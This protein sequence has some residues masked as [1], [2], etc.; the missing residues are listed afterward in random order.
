MATLNSGVTFTA[1]V[2]G[3]HF[4]SVAPRLFTGTAGDFTLSVSGVT[5]PWTIGAEVV[6]G[7][8]FNDVLE[9][10]AGADIVSGGAG[11]DI[12][13]GQSGADIIYGN[14]EIDTL[15]GGDGNDI[16]YGGQNNALNADG[17]RAIEDVLNT[18]GFTFRQVQTGG[19]EFLFGGSGDDILYGNFG[20]DVFSGDTGADTI[21]GGQGDDEANGGSENDSLF[22]NRG[23]DILSGDTG[24]DTLNGGT[25]NDTLAGGTG[26]DVFVFN[27]G[28]GTDVIGDFVAGTDAIQVSANLNGNSTFAT[29]D[30]VSLVTG[31]GTTGE[32]IINLG[33]NADG[34]ANSIKLTGVQANAVTSDFF[35]FG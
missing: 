16:I 18:D 15:S 21:F 7:A 25:G 26:S 4:V 34:S 32:A 19:R 22:G 35:T 11:A 6:N 3:L 28:S 12:L 2:T 8:G 17:T 13:L 23:N 31:D 10:N 5:T 33:N 24:S 29:E 1:T 20:T 14:Q 30:Y 9:A 27:A